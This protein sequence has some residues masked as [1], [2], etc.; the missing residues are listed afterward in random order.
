MHFD[1]FEE[2]NEDKKIYVDFFISG[3]LQTYH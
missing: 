3:T 2:R 1:F